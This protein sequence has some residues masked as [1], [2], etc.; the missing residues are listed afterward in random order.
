VVCGGGEELG[1]EV[2]VTCWKLSDDVREK[3]GSLTR[4]VVQCL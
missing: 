3:G 1:E 2:A 4:R